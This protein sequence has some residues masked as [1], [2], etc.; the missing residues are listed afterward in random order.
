MTAMFLSLVIASVI[1]PLMSPGPTLNPQVKSDAAGEIVKIDCDAWWK[2]TDQATEEQLDREHDKNR[3]L[4]ALESV[5]CAG[6][7]VLK[8][9]VYGSP[10]DVDAAMGWYPIPENTTGDGSDTGGR[11]GEEELSWLTGTYRLNT[12]ESDN[13]AQLTAKLMKSL[14]AEQRKKYESWIAE[15]EPPRYLAISPNKQMVTFASSETSP[16]TF[17]ADARV[18]EGTLPSGS[19]L[20]LHAETGKRRLN[21]TWNLDDVL[22]T[23][24]EIQPGSKGEKLVITRTMNFAGHDAPVVM[25]AVYDRESAIADLG[26]G[27]RTTAGS[28][29]GTTAG[30][31][32]GTT[33]GSTAGT[34]AGSTAGTA[35]GN[36]ANPAEEGYLIAVLLGPLTAKTLPD[37]AEISLPVMKPELESAAI[38]GHVFKLRDKVQQDSFRLAFQLDGIRLGA[39]TVIPFKCRLERIV[40]SSGDVI[41][42]EQN[43]R[44][45]GDPVRFVLPVGVDLP[46]GTRFLFKLSTCN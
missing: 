5:R 44:L 6:A 24:V 20:K 23:K 43:L 25:R 7:G 2:K 13:A 17:Q 35:S 41:V 10:V 11:P 1:L 26:L 8:I 37:S 12:S 32:A 27:S 16:L 3:K 40:S 39:G 19:L 30:S 4:Y 34:T 9:L 18:R 33:A 46:A 38:Q 42:R 21:I 45:A 22:T 15:F 29:A 36:T 28:T 31:T 14:K